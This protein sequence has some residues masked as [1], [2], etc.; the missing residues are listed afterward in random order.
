[1]N[2][3]L[4]SRQLTLFSHE[5]LCWKEL[6]RDQQQA[7]E[8][9]L[10]LMLERSLHHSQPEATQDQQRQIMEKSRV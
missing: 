1:M 4:R 10:S 3:Q 6:A 8:E 5:F 2:N 7:L 9:V